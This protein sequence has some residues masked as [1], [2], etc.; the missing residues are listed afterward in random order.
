[1]DDRF[2]RYSYVKSIES[3]NELPIIAMGHLQAIGSS[4]SQEDRW[5]RSVV[6]GLEAISANVF[7]DNLFYT[8]LGHLHKPQYVG[9][10]TNV[11]YSGSP[12]PMSFSEKNYRQGVTLISPKEISFLEFEPPARLKRVPSVPAGIDEVLAELELLPNGK[13]NENSPYI[14]VKVL[15]EGPEPSLRH[16]IEEALVE[17]AVRLTRIEAVLRESEK[18]GKMLSAQEVK[19]LSPLEVAKGYYISKYSGEEMPKSMEKLFL[20]AMSKAQKEVQK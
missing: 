16:K 9:G 12:L 10:R 18:S 14:E 13:V 7:N 5:E 15:V 8:A 1:M 11:R 3:Y 17:K 4:L 19:E 6:G 20:E 2:N